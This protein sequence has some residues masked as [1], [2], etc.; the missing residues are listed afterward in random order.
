M[1]RFAFRAL[2]AA[3]ALCALSAAGCGSPTATVSGTVEF[4]KKPLAGCTVAL[5]C[6]DKQILHAR[7]DESGRYSVPN[8]PGGPVRV[9]VQAQRPLPFSVRSA[10]TPPVLPKGSGPVPPLVNPNEP[11]V[12]IPFRYAH[13]EES[14][15][16]FVAD[17]ARVSYD[18]ALVP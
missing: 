10:A 6:S 12:T 11:T 9:T 7:T 8:V 2:C 3:T 16:V 15:L 18:V 14:G 4:Q 17:S 5:Y 13:P 1:P